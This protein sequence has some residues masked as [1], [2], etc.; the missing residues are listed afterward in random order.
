VTGERGDDHRVEAGIGGL[1]GAH[2]RVGVDPKDRQVSAVLVDQVRERRHA[3][4]AFAANRRD[5]RRF[6][7]LDDRQRIAQLLKHDGLPCDAVALLGPDIAHLDGHDSGRAS[8]LRQHRLEHLRANRIAGPSDI[9]GK[10]KSQRT[11]ALGTSTLPLRP[12]QTQVWASGDRIYLV[13]AS[14]LSR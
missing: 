13:Q 2:V 3:Y 9:E 12:H 8:V 6:V 4:R 10:L 1:A 14:L 5:T 7:F 11:N